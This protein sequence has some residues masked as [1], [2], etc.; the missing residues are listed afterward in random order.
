MTS[1][2]F[3]QSHQPRKI[4]MAKLVLARWQMML[5]ERITF[6]EITGGALE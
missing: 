5:P 6:R 2:S 3:D 4:S 1:F